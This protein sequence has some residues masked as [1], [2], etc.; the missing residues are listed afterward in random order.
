M[1]TAHQ[2]GAVDQERNEVGSSRSPATSRKASP[3]SV[4][5]VKDASESDAFPIDTNAAASLIS[6]VA[7]AVARGSSG[8]L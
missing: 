2:R 7:L 1:S 6:G 4:D 8:T 3:A 5:S